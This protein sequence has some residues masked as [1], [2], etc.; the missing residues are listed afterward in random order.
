MPLYEC[1]WH[2]GL[3]GLAML[4]FFLLEEMLNPCGSRVSVTLGREKQHRGPSVSV[5]PF[6]ESH[7]I[8][9]P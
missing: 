1:F 7:R 6:S 2:D 4:L 3:F 5:P 9:C 8:K